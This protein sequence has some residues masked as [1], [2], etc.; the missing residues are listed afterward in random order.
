MMSCILLVSCGEKGWL[1]QNWCVVYSMAECVVCVVPNRRGLGG[2]WGE[3]MN[4]V[5]SGSLSR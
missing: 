4:S 2:V 1:A 5:G 3:G